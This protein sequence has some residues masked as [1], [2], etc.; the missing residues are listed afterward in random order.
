MCC[1]RYLGGGIV[2]VKENLIQMIL[3][4]KFKLPSN[5]I[6][7]L[8]PC[9]WVQCVCKNNSLTTIKQN[10]H[11]LSKRYYNSLSLFI[12]EES[13]YFPIGWTVICLGIIVVEPAF[14]IC[15][16]LI[17]NHLHGLCQFF[18]INCQDNFTLFFKCSLFKSVGTEPTVHR[19]DSFFNLQIK[20]HLP[21]RQSLKHFLQH[22]A[23]L[24][25]DPHQ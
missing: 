5:N 3:F 12:V 10:Q 6:L 22:N 20:C 2:L 14:F 1:L 19:H 4:Q 17:K 9:H 15:N 25:I 8:L 7:I 13:S 16:N 24:I 11:I 18:L 23:L 21:L